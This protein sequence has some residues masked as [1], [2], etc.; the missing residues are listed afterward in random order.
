MNPL[1]KGNSWKVTFIDCES[2]DMLFEILC[3][4]N[5]FLFVHEN[6]IEI[7]IHENR[8]TNLMESDEIVVVHEVSSD[9]IFGFF[10]IDEFL[11]I[12]GVASKES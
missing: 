7:K 10:P 1:Q 11:K 5:Y 2:Q 8:K 3:W 12:F 4:N 9:I 6:K